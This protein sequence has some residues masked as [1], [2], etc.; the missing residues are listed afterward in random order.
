[1]RRHQNAGTQP[2]LAMPV[3]QNWDVVAE[4]WYFACRSGEIGVGAVKAM[5]LCGQHVALYRGEDGAVRAL[6]G[7]CPHMG[8][9]LGIGTVKGDRIAC[10]FHHW[11]F[12]G[13]G[14]CR[15]I[16]C[17]EP[18]PPNACLQPYATAENSARSGVPGAGGGVSAAGFRGLGG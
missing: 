11:E 3:F 16:P 8:T 17:G 15:H 10:F 7:F 5:N 4:A 1:M 18:T 2:F 9:D 12:D 6:D 14:A 13:T